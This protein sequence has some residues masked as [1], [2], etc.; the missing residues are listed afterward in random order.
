MTTRRSLLLRLTALALTAAGGLPA[1][2]AQRPRPL[3]AILSPARPDAAV[4]ALVNEPFM[5]T[6]A[7]LGYRPG[8]DIDVVERY[9]DGDESRLP[10]LAGELVALQPQVLFTNT[11]AAATAAARATRTIPIVVGPAGEYVLKDLAGGSLARP[12]TNVTGFA[13]TSPDID[14]KCIA[15]LLEATPLLR[16]VGV[17]VNPDNPGMREHPQRQAAALGAQAPT[18]VRIEA[19]GL[20]DIDAALAHAAAQ[21]VQALFVADD[22]YIA[23]D[24]AAR[25][26]V[27]AFA[28]AAR[29]PVV[30]SHLPYAR[31]GALLAMGPS[32]PVLAAR[33]AGYVDRILKGARIAD[34]PVEL[35]SVLVT[36]VN[37]RAARALAL[38]LP[39]T[40][41]ARADEVIE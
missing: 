36:V 26:R 19:T 3:L 16:R 6:L 28:S 23:A 34:L 37:R 22:S 9:A 14:S 1:T 8:R 24:P 27:L 7:R 20:G 18:L 25:R 35:P 21:E 17:M 29:M 33:A 30:S 40:L 2:Q 12:T 11:N 41:I 10:A 4:I 31:D 32:I 13:L 15:L 5:Q 38:K 39:P